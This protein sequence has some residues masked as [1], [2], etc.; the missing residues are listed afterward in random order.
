MKSETESGQTAGY[1]L[2]QPAWRAYCF[3]VTQ[4]YYNNFQ[5]VKLLKLLFGI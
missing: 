3:L 1:L 2:T 4:L 5:R